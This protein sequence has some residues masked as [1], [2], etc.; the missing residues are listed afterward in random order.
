[1]WPGDYWD[2]RVAARDIAGHYMFDY[3]NDGF[4]DDS[5]FNDAFAAGAAF[6][7]FVD[8]EAPQPAVSKF[9]DWDSEGNLVFEIVNPDELLGGSDVV[10][11]KAYD[12]V[13]VEISVLPSEDTCEVMK[14]E[15]FVC[16]NADICMHVGTS[17]DPYHY[18]VTFEPVSMGLIPPQKIENGWWQ[19][20]IKAVLY[21]SLNNSNETEVDWY[22]L[23]ITPSQAIITMPFNDSYVWGD[24]TLQSKALNA[25]EICEVCYEYKA[26]GGDWQPVLNG[27]T[28][29]SENDWQVVWHT[30]NT[31]LDGVYYLRAVATDCNNNVDDDPPTIM[32]TVANGLPDVV[33][34]D[35]RICERECPDS[36]L[37]TLGYVGDEVTLYASASSDI[38]I[39]KVEFW[40]KDIFTFPSDW[41]LI[42]TDAF[43]TAGKYSVVWNTNSLADGRYHVKARAYSA[44]G[45]YADSDP[46]TISVD[47][48]APFAQVVSIMGDPHPDGMNITY[49]DVIDIELV[50]IDSTSDD[51][52]TRCYNSG[53]V[54]I[55]VCIENC[56]SG[57]EIT[58]CFEVSPVYDGFHTVQW[59]TSG[60][61]FSGCS[62]CYYIYVEA[63]DCLGNTDTSSMVTVYVSDVTAPI[64]TIGGFDGNY[65]YGYSSEMVSTLLFEYAD[66]GS[67]N[68]IPIGWSSIADSDCNLYKTSWD[69]LS[70]DDG[71]YQVRVISHD[72]CSNQDDDMA[73]LAFF[74]KDGTTITPYN[75][76]V[77]EAMS[78]LKN[79]CVGGMHGVVLQ[80]VQSGTPVMISRYINNSGVYSYECVHMQ[81][82]L[83]HSI[84]FA[85][86]FYADDIRYGGSAEFFSSVTV[87][88]SP[89]PMT[90]V[91][92]VTYLTSGTFDIA[93]V[94]CDLGTHG[95]YQEGCVDLTIPEGAIDCAGP[96]ARYVWVGPTYM[97]WAP[98]YQPDILPIG[99]DNG[100]ATYISFTDC[101][102]CC[103][104]LSPYF[105]DQAIPAAGAGAQDWGEC[106]FRDGKYAKIKMCYDSEIDTDKEHL[107]VAWWDCQDGEYRFDDI[108]Y[109]ATVEGFNVE[110]H[111]VEFAT[112]CLKGPFVVVQV[113]DRECDGSILVDLFQVDPYCDGYTNSTPIFSAMISDN[114]QGTQAIDQESIQWFVDLFNP[115]DLVRF[116]DGAGSD[117]CDK[118][119]PGF[120]SFPGTGYDEVSGVF[121]AGWNDPHYYNTNTSWDCEGCYYDYYHNDYGYFC[122]PLY[123][124][125][126]GDHMATVTAM[127]DNI[128]TCTDIMNFT[129]DA[130]EPMVR[131][132]DAEGA[133]VGAN[134][135]F[136]IYFTDAEAGV[137][138]SS[139]WIDLYGDETNS[140]DPNNHQQISTITPAMLTWINDT[141]ACVDETF[142]YRYGY[143]HVY[144]YGGPDCLCNDCTTPQYYHYE[145]G[146]T[147]CVGNAT[148]VFWQYY[149]VDANDPV[150][151]MIGCG[152][153]VQK[154]R[155]TDELSGI[156]AVYAY[157]DGD[158]VEGVI[159]Q[160]AVNPEYWWYSPTAG[161]DEAEIKAVDN[162]GNF[163]IYTMGLPVDC[164]APAVEFA[165]DY[166]CKNPTIEFW[167]TDPSGVDW[168]TVNA[169][170]TGCNEACY[171]YA[172][173][174]TDN[175]DTETGKVTLEGCNF[176]CSDGNE[177]ELYVFS[178]TSYTGDGPCDMN[179][180]CGKY[181][182][183]SFVVDAKAPVIS[184]SA[185]DKRPIKITITDARSG[186]DWTTLEFYEDGEAVT[187][188]YNTETGVITY[189]PESGGADIEIRVND[190]TGC[191]LG[192]KTFEVGYTMMDAL[193]FINPH[194]FANPFDPSGSV[195]GTWIDPGLSKD[196]YVTI[197]IY[198]F[199]G[200]FVKELQAN[201]WTQADEKIFWDGTTEG[202]TPVANG[203]YLCY[204]YAS[205]DG[206]TKTAV[207]KITVL[208]ED[209]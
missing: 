110:T 82:E 143:L 200:E 101:Y 12:P 208:K 161:A 64:T 51:G 72:S 38:P 170:V 115:G 198:D 173:D 81:A 147:D 165:S 30:L 166:V 136:C 124:L 33:L 163:E 201:K 154:F 58:K 107:A 50:A 117:I 90:G 65:I 194:N 76:E 171:Y 209:K 97:E 196:C 85:G 193:V 125:S 62:G 150:I 69:P 22:I 206:S 142:E 7:V 57:E 17:T 122:R 132:A 197:K 59:N 29:S 13:T 15:Y 128:Q 157:E 25:Y 47:N 114:V 91:D 179:G 135:N 164:G 158:L 84:E 35:P 207:V 127:N 121:R 149:T 96:D 169:Y 116:Y 205:C 78:F 103:G 195:G 162:V 98:V 139:V 184:V 86:S 16:N 183:C 134:P 123:P 41:F 39:T 48:S 189:D 138:K 102:Y 100:F 80:D 89:P 104:W 43:P 192:T 42:G 3:D 126:A 92:K 75:P 188:D 34:D 204:I 46:V 109:P 60:L 99:D 137:D 182:R 202:G 190:M 95:I 131:F 151:T 112:T 155:I 187:V 63:W 153:A 45:R 111:T 49:G 119:M 73:P 26:E 168:T 130:T 74:T 23:D 113:L 55:Q 40:R 77:L 70:L 146:M 148:D 199:A 203:T 28:T 88:I 176:D 175:V 160:D 87:L 156:A 79:W 181:R 129:V 167:V 106:C 191:N 6:T 144:V 11:S 120:G 186:V 2:I 14:V 152:E 27:C 44:A 5:T 133:Y 52:W 10:F 56:E 71:T 21:D 31:I 94:K 177:I 19:G 105:G 141:T 180:N 140:P 53:L 174:L 108:Y 36:P 32:V 83:Q 54:G 20:Y 67:T 68:W 159:T 1:M 178:G 18:P 8:D 9:Q 66:S 93:T 4:F 118:W 172:P 61:E 37:D 145:C 185:Y 24:V